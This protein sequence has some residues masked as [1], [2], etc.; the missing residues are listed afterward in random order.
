VVAAIGVANL[1]VSAAITFFYFRAR[2]ASPLP[3]F[4]YLGH[5][6]KVLR[7]VLLLGLTRKCGGKRF[8]N[9]ATLARS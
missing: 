5:S 4:F 6:R 3:N 9:W 8:A 1:F 7:T 2:R